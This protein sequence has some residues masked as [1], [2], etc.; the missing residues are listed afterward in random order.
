MKKRALSLA[1]LFAGVGGI[2]RGFERAGFRAVWQVEIDA[3]ASA[4]LADR[5]PSTARFRDVRAVGSAATV[6]TSARRIKALS[7]PLGLPSVEALREARAN[8]VGAVDWIVGGFP[9]QDVS[10]AGKR[11]GLAGARTGLFWQFMRIVDEL[12]PKGVLLENVPGLLSSNGGR[13]FHTVLSALAERGFRRAYRILDSQYF[14][15]PQRRRRVFIVGCARESGLDPAAILFES[16]G[17]DRDP[18]ETRAA[19]PRVASTLRGRAA[20]PGVN[21]PGRGGEDDQNLIAFDTTQIANPD[22]RS[23]LDVGRPSHP[24]SA[25]AH[26]PAV[27]FC[28][29]SVHRGVGQ[30]HNT[31]YIA[32]PLGGGNYGIGRRTEDDPNLVYPIS[33][34][35]AGGRSGEAVTLSKDASGNARLRPPSLGIGEAGA[36]AFTV[37]SGSVPAIAATLNSGGNSGGFRTEPGEHL[38]AATLQGAGNSAQPE[39][40]SGIVIA[41]SGERTR[42]LVGSMHKRHDDDT[43]TLIASPV[44]A[45]AGHHGHSSPRGDGRDNIVPQSAGVRRLTPLECER[46]QGFPDGWTCRCGNGHRGTQFCTCPDTP[47]YKQCGNAVSEPVAFWIAQRIVSIS[48]SVK[49]A[50]IA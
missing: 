22:N 11:A 33:G 25:S 13:D 17:G 30:G 4:V 27:A 7:W 29:P 43:D 32:G 35:A 44:T 18:A 16:A 45:S 5:F 46:L 19:R 23:R 6:L 10:V 15:V 47:R 2:D 20:K 1:S 39:P 3:D 42:A 31:N 21:T 38:I 24:L 36:P 40:G 34:D 50:Q 28:I 14:G 41:S 8:V 37:S 26:A 12:Q 49:K 48:G 9:C